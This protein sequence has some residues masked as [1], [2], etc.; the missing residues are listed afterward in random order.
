[1][2]KANLSG[3]R[4][5]DVDLSSAD[6]SSADLSGTN[7]EVARSLKGTDLRGVKG[8]SKKQLEAYKARG[9]IIDKDSTA[10]SLSFLGI[11]RFGTNL[12]KRFL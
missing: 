9:A 11:F 1:M 12:V 5:Y 8:L 10:N 6:L 2:I 7:L 4:L 3:A